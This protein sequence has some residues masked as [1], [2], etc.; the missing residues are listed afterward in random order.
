VSEILAVCRKTATFCP[1]YCFDPRRHS[2]W[3]KLLLCRRHFLLFCSDIKILQD[4]NTV[5]S[6]T[7]SQPTNLPYVPFSLLP[8]SKSNVSLVLETKA[9][10]FDAAWKVLVLRKVFFTLLLQS[11][12]SL[13]LTSA[14][15]YLAVIMLQCIFHQQE[16]VQQSDTSVKLNH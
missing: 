13:L 5:L 12:E 15:V 9:K 7:E 3:S 6:W 10:T 8:L 4:L 16:H 1:S 14:L 11:V 2:M